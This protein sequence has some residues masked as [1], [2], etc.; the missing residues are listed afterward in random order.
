M[1]AFILLADSGCCPFDL[2]TLIKE[3]GMLGR[4][5]WQGIEDCLQTK[6]S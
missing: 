3:A 2:H 5:M 4:S 6:A 1:P